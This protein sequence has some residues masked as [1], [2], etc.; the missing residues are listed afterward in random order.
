M[1]DK[2]E[3]NDWMQ[4]IQIAVFAQFYKGSGCN[5]LGNCVMFQLLLNSIAKKASNL[6]IYTIQIC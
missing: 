3:N 5:V 6:R 1:Y 2:A 4:V